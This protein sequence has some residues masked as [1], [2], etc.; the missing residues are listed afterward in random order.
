[1]TT[2]DKTLV[3][4]LCSF[5]SNCHS[6]WPSY[7]YHSTF[8]IMCC[9]AVIQS[10]PGS[11]NVRHGIIFSL[12]FNLW[13][14]KVISVG[15]TNK[16]WHRYKQWCLL[17]M[18]AKVGRKVLWCAAVGLHKE[19]S[20]GKR[21]CGREECAWAE[22]QG[23][24]DGQIP[25]LALDE[26][27]SPWVSTTL[28]QGQFSLCWDNLITFACIMDIWHRPSNAIWMSFLSL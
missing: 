3:H 17:I 1:M 19:L 15:N 14:N 8:C 11:F 16:S 26:A 22:V 20:L 5:L 28:C 9:W 24:H 23:N 21:T 12:N 27:A 13:E 2:F 7:A 18:K 10:I 6:D 4:T 25:T